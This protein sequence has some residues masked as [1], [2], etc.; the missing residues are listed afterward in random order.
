MSLQSF[1]YI[2]ASMATFW[3]YDYACSL[4]EEWTFLLRSRWNKMKGLYIITRYLPFIFLATDLF[5]YFTP[6]ENSGKCRVLENTQSGLGIVLVIVSESFFILRTYVLWNRSRILLVAILFTSFTFLVASFCIVFA[7]GVPAAYTTSAIPGITGCY[8][9]STSFQYVVAFLFLSVFEL[10]L[11]V[12]TLICAVQN[13]RINR[14]RLYVVLVN[15]NISYYVCGFLLSV[16]NISA[17]LLLQD[18]YQTFFY[19][20]SYLQFLPRAC[21]SIS[22]R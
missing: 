7:A 10:G 3:T 1:K 18:S 22:G 21:T 12:L 19:N 4:H 2:L 6:N 5:M 13:W 17:S 14:S 8:R 16:T 15:H 20:L 9:N 11:M